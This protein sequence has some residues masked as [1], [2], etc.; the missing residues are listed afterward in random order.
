MP[1][2]QLELYASPADKIAEELGRIDPD[3][4]TPL[5]ALGILARLKRD[6]DNDGRSG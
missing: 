2:K 4:T 6:I 1:E 5:E 3:A